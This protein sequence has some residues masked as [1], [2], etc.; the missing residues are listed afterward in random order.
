MS[1]NFS[2]GG[3]ADPSNGGADQGR[4]GMR[5]ISEKGIGGFGKE[6]S[7]RIVGAPINAGTSRKILSADSEELK[8]SNSKPAF[9]APG[10]VA[11]SEEFKVFWGDNIDPIW[12]Q[13]KRYFSP[14]ML[15]IALLILLSLYL[16]STILFSP[17][18]IEEF[19]NSLNPF[20]PK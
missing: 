6:G 2:A 16:C 3:K 13:G 7:S 10:S 19:M 14:F 9:S 18:E 8:K 17:V 15:I 5:P 4:G 11:P 1:F 20:K 12:F